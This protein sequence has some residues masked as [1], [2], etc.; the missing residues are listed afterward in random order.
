MVAEL[1]TSAFVVLNWMIKRLISVLSVI[2]I[3]DVVFKAVLS[4][5]DYMMWASV[6]RKP[7]KMACAKRI[8]LVKSHITVR[9]HTPAFGRTGI[10]M[11]ITVYGCEC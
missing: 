7:R 10:R 5:V 9:A 1:F 6:K 11:V 4:V 3:R 2:V 8:R